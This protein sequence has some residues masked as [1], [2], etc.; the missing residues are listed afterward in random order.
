[1]AQV[2]GRFAS[3]LGFLMAAAGSAVGLG[4]VWGFPSQT[5]NNGG[6]AFVVM[7]LVLAFLLAW[8]ALMAELVIGRHGQ[9]NI[10]TSMSLGRG[11]TKR[12]GAL[13]GW[14]GMLTA[15]L[16]LAFYAIV[17]GWLLGY[18]AAPVSE[19]LGMSSAASWLT[20]FDFTRNVSLTAV[21]LALTMAIVVGGVRGGIE[22]WSTR[23]MPLLLMLL[24]G[25]IGY[26]LT[27]PGADEGLSV[28]LTPQ[29]DR[30]FDADLM[31]SA[32]G[33]AF[34]SLSLGVGAMLIYG[35]YLGPEQNLPRLGV[36]VTLIDVGIAFLAGLLVIP[37]MYAARHLGVEIFDADGLLK[38][39]DT[40]LFDTLP[41]LFGQMGGAG[42]VLM[43]A[44][45]AL[46]SVAGITSSISMLEVP[47]SFVVERGWLGRRA[48]TLTVGAAIMAISLTIAANFGAL[49]GLVIM[50]TTQYSQ[51]LVALVMCLLVGW[52]M[53]RHALLKEIQ[54]GAP[55]IESRLFW[56]IW[57]WYVRL[58]CPL[59]IA[60]VFAHSL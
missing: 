46:M 21:F 37:A 57:P 26:V 20:T 40:L 12:F 7:Y 60:L 17:A 11:I 44:F 6:G 33:Q 51:P 54:S 52:A 45:F 47:V 32:M 22:K 13:A 55:D 8:P 30:I 36:L 4:N 14:A 3:R 27:L 1:M 10:V 43:V 59:C 9:A 28:Y 31:L 18:T 24:V 41:A 19:A 29:W 15:S 25:L 23:L 50:L 56:K 53:S 48:A 34:F 49:F 39:S 2:R 58:I 35:S 5:A 16:I 38:S 42:D